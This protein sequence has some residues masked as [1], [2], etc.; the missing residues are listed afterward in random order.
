MRFVS[1]ILLSVSLLTALSSTAPAQRGADSGPA[2]RC[3]ST[4]CFNQTR[5]RDFEVVDP[6]TLIVYIGRQ[7]CAFLVQLTGTFCDLTFL[8]GNEIVFR[9]SRVGQARSVPVVG[10]PR[11]PLGQG[12]IEQ[13]QVCASDIHLGIEQGPFTTAGGAPDDFSGLSCR[14]QDVRALTDDERLQLYVDRELVA[15]P[16][17]FGTGRVEVPDEPQEVSAEEPDEASATE[18]RE[19]RR[20]RRRR[21]RDDD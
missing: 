5:M 7:R 2:D 9:P 13:P 11:D 20:R 16:P 6:A 15:P 4:D 8:P 21:D 17:P 18:S 19:E 3:E 12:G 10:G 1:G 14:I